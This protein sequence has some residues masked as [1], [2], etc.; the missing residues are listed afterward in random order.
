MIGHYDD[1]EPISQREMRHIGPG[2]S[3]HRDC[4][5]DAKRKRKRKPTSEQEWFQHLITSVSTKR[6]SRTFDLTQ[7]SAGEAAAQATGPRA[8]VI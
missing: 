6:P 1:L 5:G 2:R 7:Q 3:L 4:G 8:A